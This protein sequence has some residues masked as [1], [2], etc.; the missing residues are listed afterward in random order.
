LKL[1]VDFI[2]LCPLEPMAATLNPTRDSPTERPARAMTRCECACLSFAEIAR[3]I[4]EESQSLAELGRR[5]GCARTCTACLPDLQA[6][7]RVSS[8]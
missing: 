5:T 7:L 1:K 2:I 3:R 8:P 6:Y 4:R